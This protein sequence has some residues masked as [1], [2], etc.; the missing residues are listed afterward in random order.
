VIAD[1]V[2]ERAGMAADLFETCVMTLIATMRLGALMLTNAPMAAVTCPPALGGSAIIASIVGL[3]LAG[4]LVG[5]TESC[6]GT[7][8]MPVCHVAETAET[9]QGSNTAV[10]LVVSIGGGGPCRRSRPRAC[11][12][13]H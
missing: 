11:R 9:G 10:G 8:C 6:T 7:G 1:T 4:L 12:G 13:G 5:V 2:G 3:A